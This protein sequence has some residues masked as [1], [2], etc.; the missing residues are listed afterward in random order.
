MNTKFIISGITLAAIVTL[1]TAAFVPVMDANA[2]RTQNNNF[3]NAYVQALN[4]QVAPI[5]VGGIATG[6]GGSQVNSG[7]IGNVQQGDTSC[8]LC[9]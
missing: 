6:Q 9:G 4:G 7:A 2:Q 5:N 8:V 1:V 3:L